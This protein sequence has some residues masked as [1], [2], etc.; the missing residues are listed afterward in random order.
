M[1]GSKERWTS[2]FKLQ[3]QESVRMTLENMKL[4]MEIPHY[5]VK[6]AEGGH[7][8]KLVEF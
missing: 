2:N 3:S 6:F 5:G 4:L 8:P 7:I 1:S